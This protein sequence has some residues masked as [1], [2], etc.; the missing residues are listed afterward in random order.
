MARAATKTT[1]R[2]PGRPAA[3]AETKKAAPKPAA[4]SSK[5]KSQPQ[6]AKA[7]PQKNVSAKAASKPQPAKAAPAAGR[8][9]VKHAA[10]VPK[11]N[12]EE[13]RVRVEK[14]ERSNMLLRDKN[15]E[16]RR[17]VTEANARIAELEDAA[18]RREQLAAKMAAP[19]PEVA[20]G[21]ST[22]QQKSRPAAKPQLQKRARP[23]AAV[24]PGAA[25]Q[26]LDRPGEADQ[27]MQAPL[28]E[29]F[30]A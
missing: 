28:N 15:K 5:P 2:I 14:L 8:S 25:A 6:M 19:A 16:L 9:A 18:A 1:G 20:P 17:A 4:T 24:P 7:A 29:E 11:P 30:A 13:L 3:K 12:K 27:K 22:K 21:K 23:G 10:P 26:E